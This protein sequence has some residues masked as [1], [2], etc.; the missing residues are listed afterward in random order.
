MEGSGTDGDTSSTARRLVLT[1]SRHQRLGRV[2]GWK[3]ET[4]TKEKALGCADTRLVARPC[5][6]HEGGKPAQKKKKSCR[7]SPSGFGPGAPLSLPP[8]ELAVVVREL[9]WRQ[10]VVISVGDA[11]LGL[12]D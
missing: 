12:P 11:G 2:L 9:V 3:G 7:T 10:A 8:S 5:T 4:W 1:R 6:N